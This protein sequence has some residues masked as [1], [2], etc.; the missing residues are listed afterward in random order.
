MIPNRNWKCLSM[1]FSI[2]LPLVQ[3]RDCIYVVVDH[4]TKFAHFFFI[5]T[6]YTTI[7]VVEL[8]FKEIFRLH[9]LPQSIVSD[10]DNRFMS[11]FW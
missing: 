6:T 9:G 2:G 10:R 5:T 8:L 11:H 3:G 7:E 4:L 1:V